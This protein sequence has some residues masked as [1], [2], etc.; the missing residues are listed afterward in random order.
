MIKTELHSPECIF[1]MMG[2]T[3]LNSKRLFLKVSSYAIKEDKSINQQQ[4]Y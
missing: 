4:K 3:I 2:K 1:A